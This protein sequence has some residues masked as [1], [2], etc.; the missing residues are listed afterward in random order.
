MLDEDQLRIDTFRPSGDEGSVPRLRVTHQPTGVVHESE[1]R[2]DEDVASAL[3]RVKS[4]LESE[5]RSRGL[6]E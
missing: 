5:L 2:L 6:L 4:E 3:D 1:V